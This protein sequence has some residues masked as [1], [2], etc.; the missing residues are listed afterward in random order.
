[1]INEPLPLIIRR[2]FP[3]PTPDQLAAFEGV[4]TGYV[5]DAMGGQGAMDSAVKPLFGPLAD[6]NLSTILGVAL[7]AE[8]GPAEILATM[9]A[10][11]ILEKGDVVVAAMQGGKNCAAAGD[12]FCGM[13]KNKGAAGFVTDGEM[14]DY[15]GIL[16]TGL[17][18]FCTGLSPNSPYSNGP[19]RVGFD[20][21]VGGRHV[22][23]GDV[24]IADI[25]G[26]VVVPFALIDEVIS[27]IR[28]ISIVENALDAKV[29]EG[30][31]EV[32]AVSQMIAD[33][34]AKIID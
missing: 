20:A 15:N 30:F 8:N 4:P 22:Q 2:K 3:R 31:C 10:L 13:L 19:A 17:P 27:S 9:G 29:R 7:V 33:G 32:P 18:V 16:E 12:R 24:I 26:V 11:H 6:S 23:S 21:V 25:D 34:R 5:C 28:D 14:R 1:M